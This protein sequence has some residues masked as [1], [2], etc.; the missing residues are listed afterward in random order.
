MVTVHYAS[1]VPVL[2][3]YGP[4]A[5]LQG[6]T[7]FKQSLDA[8]AHRP[9]LGKN[10][11][12][13]RCECAGPAQVFMFTQRRLNAFPDQFSITTAFEYPDVCVSWKINTS[14]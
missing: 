2:R 6:H 12:A 14:M 10:N 4:R 7:W 1:A 11:G 8:D 13:A 5:R 9:K 3:P